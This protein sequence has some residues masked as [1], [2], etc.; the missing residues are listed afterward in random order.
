MLL[1]VLGIVV[2]LVLGATFY[3]CMV[4]PSLAAPIGA[5]GGIASA[6]ATAFGVAIA[7]RRR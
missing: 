4:H 5:V 7:L 1:L 3:L 6:L 2:V